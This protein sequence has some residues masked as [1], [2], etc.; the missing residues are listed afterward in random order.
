MAN[1]GTSGAEL[2]HTKLPAEYWGISQKQLQEFVLLARD[3]V[4]GR[5]PGIARPSNLSAK[6]CKKMGIPHYDDTKFNDPLIGPNMYQ[7]NMSLIKPLTQKGDPIHNIPCLSYSLHQNSE[8]GLLCDLFI[9]HA[10]AEGIFEFTNT[11][12]QEWPTLCRG[13]YICFLSNP[14]NM[15]SFISKLVKTPS[16]TPFYRVLSCHAKH[17]VMVANCNVPI[18]SRLWCVYEAYCAQ[19]YGIPISVAGD[20]AHFSTNARAARHALKA[21]RD[22]VNA[23]MREMS[24]EDAMEQAASDMDIIAAGIYHTRYGKARA[25]ATRATALAMAKMQ[26][27][28]DVRRAQCSNADDRDAIHSEVHGLED[29]INALICRLIVDDQLKRAPRVPAKMT[30]YWGQDLVEGIRAMLPN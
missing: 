30:W 29:Q 8:C 17:I 11:V 12:V 18:H 4:D 23:K 2:V 1:G 6:Q 22:T 24:I 3:L 5:L 26:R 19:K 15:D 16:Q 28:L 27:S 10:W 25:K 9:S 20:P 14:Q 7:I 13:A 21:I